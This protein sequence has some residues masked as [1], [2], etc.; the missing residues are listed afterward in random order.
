MKTSVITSGP[1]EENCYLVF[2]PDTFEAAVIDPGGAHEV[3]ARARS[4]RARV[5]WILMTH[6]HADHIAGNAG[7]KAA[8]PQAKL[9]I[10]EADARMLVD[11][12]LNLSAAFGAPTTSPPADLL[13]RDRDVVAVG[14][15]RLEVIHVPGHTP[16]G[17]AFYSRVEPGRATAAESKGPVLFSGDALFRGGIGRVDFPSGSA[18]QLIESIRTRLLTLPA[19]TIVNPGHGESTTIGEEARSNPFLT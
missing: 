10:H 2:C 17:I 15:I 1:F 13:L 19:D 12:E 9:A 4:L 11:A 16:G 6:G 18:A 8:L 5:K 3:L 14:T 7:L